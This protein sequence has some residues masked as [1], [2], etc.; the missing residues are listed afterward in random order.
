MLLPTFIVPSNQA[1]VWFFFVVSSMTAP[2][3]VGVCLVCRAKLAHK[4]KYFG[5]GGGH[6]YRIVADTDC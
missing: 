5:R 2:D 4:K 3:R 6:V 1:C